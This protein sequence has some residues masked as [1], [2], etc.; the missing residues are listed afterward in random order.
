M[1]IES[2]DL[3]PKSVVSG[4]IPADLGDFPIVSIDV[5][6]TGLHWYRGHKAFGIA[7]AAYDGD[8]MYKGY[9]DIRQR[10][11]YVEHL[12]DEAKRIK[13]LVNHNMK[14]DVHMLRE[15]GV[16]VFNYDCTS[17]RAALL[18]EHEPSFSLDSLGKKYLG[19][20]KKTGVYEE[21]AALFGG[22]ADRSIQM[23]NLHRAPAELAGDYAM[24]D[25]MLAILLYI[26]QQKQFADSSMDSMAQVVKMERDLIPVLVDI[27]KNGIRIDRQ[28]TANRMSEIDAAIDQALAKLAKKVG[29]QVNPNS[30][31]QMRELFDVRQD[32]EKRWTTDTGFP[33]VATDAGNPSID[34]DVLRALSDLQD[35]RAGLIF[36]ARKLTKARSFLKD[37]LLGHEVNGRVYPNYNQTRSESGLGTGTGRF[38]IDDPAMQQIPARDV[39]IAELVRECVLAEEGEQWVCADW[40]QFEFRWFTHYVNEPKLI[41]AYNEDAGVDF[42]KMVA[43]ITG[44]PRSARHAGDPNAKQINL[45]MVFGMGSGRLAAEMGMPYTVKKNGHKEYLEPGPEAVAVFDKYHGAIPGVQRLLKQASSIARSRGY[46]NTIL[47]R[48]LRF[49]QGQYHKAGGLVFQGT[50]ADCIKMKMIEHHARGKEH[51]Y[52]TRLSVHDELDFSV[53]KGKNSKKV[54]EGIK[55][56]QEDLPLCRVPIR[57]SVGV[58]ANW[59]EASK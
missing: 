17:V 31:K 23:K 51:G 57:A 10:P 48:R 32:E 4:E 39:E 26:H 8:T 44:L 38:S 5:E 42:H 35:E 46:V 36:R 11:R 47:G 2:L 13:L 37:H 19:M 50:S 40:E 1:R 52:S 54:I 53:P 12:R 28:V 29:R 34:A 27:E 59:W 3:K 22:K 49:P 7:V 45:G 24:D 25:P 55:Q 14:F 30:P 58:G 15:A 21:L 18:N 43:G 33:L 56:V 16:P 9:V 41:E 6:T 20:G